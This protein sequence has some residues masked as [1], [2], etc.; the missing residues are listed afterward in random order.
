M[1]RLSDHGS[2]KRVHD[3]LKARANIWVDGPELQT[4]QVGGSEGTKRFRELRAEGFPVEARRHPDPRRSIWQYRYVIHEKKQE[5]PSI[6]M[7]ALT[8]PELPDSQAED[9]VDTMLG[10]EK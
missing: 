7:W 2:K 6:S 10:G 5:A 1:A 3:Y 4:P 9:W 8:A